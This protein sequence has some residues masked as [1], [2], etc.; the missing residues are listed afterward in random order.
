MR[1]ELENIIL[2]DM[3]ESDIEDYVRWFTVEREW[4]NWDAP[5]E[6][7]DTDE[8]SERRRWTES[9]ESRKDRPDDVRRYRLEIEWNGRHIGSVNAYHID[10]NY[11]WIGAAESG[12]TVHLAVGICL[13]EP[14]LWGNGIGTNALCAFINYQL[15]IGADEIYTQTWSGNVRMIRCA[16]KLGFVECNRN[17]GTREVDGQQYDGLSPVT[18]CR[19]RCGHR[20][21]QTAFS[22]RTKAAPAFHRGRFDV[23]PLFFPQLSL[24]PARAPA[25]GA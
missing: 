4:E 18:S 1:I 7:E 25:G 2:R 3:I 24:F 6:K 21:L 19:G 5:W 13:Y 10:E 9:Y 22:H 20:P 23:I 8:D 12:Q 14:N 16:E 17:V 11:E 15:K